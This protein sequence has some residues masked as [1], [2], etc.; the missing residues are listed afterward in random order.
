MSE[1][2]RKIVY[3]GTP[4]YA[5]RILEVLLEREEFE[6]ELVLTQPDR[7]VG[8]KKILTPPPVKS[9]AQER[10]IE[11]RQPSTLREEGIRKEIRALAPDFI[12][13]AAYGQLLPREILEI[14]PCIN[15]HASLLPKYRGASPIQQCL[16]E[17]ESV[18]GVTA[19]LMEEGLDSGPAL[20]YRMLEIGKEEGLEN[21]TERLTEAAA[22]LTPEVLLRFGTLQP[23]PQFD[24]LAS[25]CRK[26]RRS[27][28][29]VAFEDAR[30]LYR[31]SRA[32]EGWPGVF[33]PNGLK[34]L[35]IELIEG[36]VP[37]TPGEILAVGERSFDVGCGRG[38]IRIHRL[39]PPGKKPMDADAYLRGRGVELGDSLL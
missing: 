35:E 22:Q 38:S 24:A 4:E 3:M 14:A 20:A 5:R 36:E 39:Q 16:L 26:V 11:V 8:R 30:N 37:H 10:G 31:K 21:L 23:L 12:V 2:K 13:V 32:F 9:L 27:D 18:T 1:R 17:G 33:L 19:M 7:P 28:G 25:H 34:L 29:E 6:V 15:L